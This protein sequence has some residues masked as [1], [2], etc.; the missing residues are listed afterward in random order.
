MN[1]INCG[2]PRKI[3]R[4]ICTACNKQRML[5]IVRGKPR[6]VWVKNCKICQKEYRAWRKIQELCAT[7]NRLVLNVAAEQ[8]STNQ[9]EH[10]KGILTHRLTAQSILGRQLTKNEVVHH[11]DGNPKNNDPKNLSVMHVRDH[12]SLHKF[13]YKVK[14]LFRYNKGDAIYDRILLG[15]TKEWFARTNKHITFLSEV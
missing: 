1:C 3:G 4:R 5:N 11:I 8:K 14:A 6:Y 7:C 15:L 2:E 13:L 12:V 9:Y 10:E